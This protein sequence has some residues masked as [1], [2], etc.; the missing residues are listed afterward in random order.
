VILLAD[1]DDAWEPGRLEAIAEAFRSEPGMAALFHDATLIGPDS[2]A[3]GQRLWQAL[4]ITAELAHAYRR[5]DP[6]E[7]IATMARGNLVTGAC[8]AFRASYRNLVLPI[9]WTWVQD[10]WIGMLLTAAAD[11]RMDDRTL[12]RYRL[13]AEQ[14]I[15]IGVARLTRLQHFRRRA[16]LGRRMTKRE[17]PAFMQEANRFRLAAQ[18]LRA[19]R[20]DHPVGSEVLRALEEKAAHFL[21]RG[22]LG[23]ADR[24]WQLV[25]QELRA[26][27]YHRYSNGWPSVAKDLLLL[28]RLGHT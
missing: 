27:R 4:G 25:R 23:R 8:L 7:R 16:Q 14:Q 6:A 21:V 24:R 1:Q 11:V 26:G 19:R 10:A 15:G 5:G 20:L 13:H 3:L 2:T 12:V 17:R 9:P 18:R 28:D 22:R